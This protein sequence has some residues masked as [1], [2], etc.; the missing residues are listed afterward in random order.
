M[1]EVLNETSSAIPANRIAGALE[2]L[3]ARHDTLQRDVTVVM[4]GAETIR[5][6]NRRD[7]SVDDTTDVLSYP[8][9][10]PDDTEMPPVPHLG[11][12]L[13]CVDVARDQAAAAGRSF[14]DEVVTL[15]AHGT[16]HLLGFD[17]ATE[18]AWRPFHEAQQQAVSWRPK[19]GS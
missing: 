15:A 4:V 16:M 18:E 13:V 14:D 8:T 11:D 7:R 10:E 19:P 17:H 1:V 5:E 6:H 2:A 3:V 12:V 9:H